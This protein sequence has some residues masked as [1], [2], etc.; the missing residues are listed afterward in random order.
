[1]FVEG[2]VNEFVVKVVFDV[3]S[4]VVL[5]VDVLDV[6]IAFVSDDTIIDVI[7]DV[8]D[9]GM[10]NVDVVTGIVFVFV[11]AATPD[12]DAVAVDT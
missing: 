2:D 11:V 6:M 5:V 10:V 8:I 12:S 9:D 3:S 1:M 7:V 4:D